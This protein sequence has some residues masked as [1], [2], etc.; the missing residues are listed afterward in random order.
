MEIPNLNNIPVF[1]EAPSKLELLQLMW[2]NN[3]INGRA[4]NYMSPL[5][6]GKR[7]VVWFYADIN[8]WKMP[9]KKDAIQNVEVK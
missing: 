7:W 1:L 3:A 2:G 4:Y 9:T 6:D 8:N 5:K